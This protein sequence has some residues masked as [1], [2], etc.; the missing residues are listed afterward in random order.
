[1]NG[2][3]AAVLTPELAGMR[4]SVRTLDPT[5]PGATGAARILGGGP[6]SPGVS[7][8]VSGPDLRIARGI[9]EVPPFKPRLPWLSTAFLG[10]EGSLAP[11]D[12]RLEPAWGSTTPEALAR[13]IVDERLGGSFWADAPAPESLSRTGPGLAIVA[14]CCRSAAV[15]RA[16]L[17][18]ACM[19]AG[20]ERTLLVLPRERGA[21]DVRRSTSRHARHLGCRVLQEP[22]D[23]WPLLDCAAE[24]HIAAQCR[25]GHALGTLA[26][27]KGLSVHVAGSAARAVTRSEAVAS[28]VDSTRYVDPFTGVACTAEQALDLVALWRRLCDANRGVAAV[29]GV[30]FWKRRRVAQFLHQGVR[31]PKF[32]TGAGALR[33]ATT[34]G[35]AIAAWASRIPPGLEARATAANIQLLRIEDGFLRSV[36]LGSDF[37]APCS[38]VLDGSGLYY[39]ATRASDLETLLGEHEFSPALRAR[40]RALV[41]R[42]VAAGMTKYN[43][44]RAA[45]PTLPRDGRRTILVPGQVADDLSVRLGAGAVTDNAGLLARVRAENPDAFIVYKPH[46]DVDAGHR[47]GALADAAVLRQADALA[48]GVSMAALIGAVDELHTMTSLAGFEALLRG[49]RVV[50]WGRPFYAGWGLTQDRAALPRRV[51]RL[52]I[53]ELAAGALLLYPRYIDP[54]SGLPCPAEILI[55][56]L[57]NPAIWRAGPLVRLRQLQGRTSM[58][59]RGTGAAE[60]C[61]ALAQPAGGQRKDAT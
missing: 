17:Q 56:R 21:G 38:I 39:D 59:Y 26:H 27:F 4:T 1:M 42:V 40:A 51:R 2:G 33:A 16:M 10:G 28:L 44:G 19:R 46:P 32:R 13:R 37:N 55:D 7:T 48:R 29:V 9:L 8:P 54:V 35:G 41:D 6:R 11:A 36:G 22:F 30:Q 23:P 53:D 31:L 52:G 18:S 34:S 3:R 60:H 12:G 47:P 49:R 14:G 25:C 15:T 20:A 61:R 5:V 50:C 57:A 43:V 24:L 58:A 45:L